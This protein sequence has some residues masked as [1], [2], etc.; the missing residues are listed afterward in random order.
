MAIG[1][2]FSVSA[3]GDI[4]YVGT[5]S[6]YTVIAFHR[7]LGDLMDDAQA[8]GNDILDITDATA[9]ERATDNYVTLNSPYNIDDEAAKHLY[10][11]SIVQ[12]TGN[13]IYDGIVVYAPAGTYLYIV[14]NSNIVSPNFWTTGLNAASS[15]GISHRFMIKVR[16]GA[17]DIDG[18]KL[19]GLTR[20]CS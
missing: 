5:T 4:R 7:W 13:I 18:R 3:S 9:S 8:S 16:T 20:Q 1:D 15:Q 2:D 12:D 17:A 10:D 11:G 6:N 19:L 14:Q